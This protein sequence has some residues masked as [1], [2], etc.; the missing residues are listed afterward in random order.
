VHDVTDATAPGPNQQYC[1]GCGKVISRQALACPNC[2]EPFNQRRAEASD[3]SRL[4]A[5]LL[6]W[7]FGIFGVHRFYV[8][9]IGTGILQLVTLGAF[10]IWTI[11]DLIFIL[12]GSFTDKQGKKL[13]VWLD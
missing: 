12:I 2:G 7:F 10:G 8:G 6:C 3:K 11:I 5:L 1:P 13:I 4:V 9:K